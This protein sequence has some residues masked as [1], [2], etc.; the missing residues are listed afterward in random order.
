[1]HGLVVHEGEPVVPR[2]AAGIHRADEAAIL[3]SLEGL[4]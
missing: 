1:M 3:G 4:P 2:L